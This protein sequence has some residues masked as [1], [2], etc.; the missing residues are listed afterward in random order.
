MEYSEIVLMAFILLVVFCSAQIPK[1]LMLLGIKHNDSKLEGVRTVVRASA[2]VVVQT[3]RKNIVAPKA[4]KTSA[5]VKKATST[6]K[7]AT[8][9]KTTKK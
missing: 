5:P 8:K 2:P 1:L 6:K 4:K 7:S 3:P 9:K